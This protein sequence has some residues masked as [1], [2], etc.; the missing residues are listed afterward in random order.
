MSRTTSVIIEI[1]L[2]KIRTKHPL[3]ASVDRYR[4]A[5]QPM[6]L[7]SDKNVVNNSKT[8]ISRKS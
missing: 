2:A 4:Y 8:K 5:N 7:H 6:V 1:A 3:N